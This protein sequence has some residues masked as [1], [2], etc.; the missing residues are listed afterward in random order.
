MARYCIA[1]GKAS[2]ILFTFHRD[3]TG[4]VGNEEFQYST[5]GDELYITISNESR[6]MM[7]TYTYKYRI[8]G[9]LLTLIL[10]QDSHDMDKVVELKRADN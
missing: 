10:Q 5:T 2:S 3:G 7:K 1:C 9:N 8:K 6:T 4:L